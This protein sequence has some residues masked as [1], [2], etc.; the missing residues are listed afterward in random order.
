MKTYLVKVPQDNM[1]KAAAFAEVFT[2]LHET[3]RGKRVAFEM[4]AT[5]QNIAFCFAA[6]E[7]TAQVVAGQI[8]A[9][10][11]IADIIQIPD[12][13]KKLRQNSNVVTSELSLARD[14]LFPLK[15]YDEF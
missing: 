15:G 7:A 6:D 10:A 2:Q 3:L 8:Y 13:T 5:G 14:D 12:F 9:I 4:L 11:P 1:Q